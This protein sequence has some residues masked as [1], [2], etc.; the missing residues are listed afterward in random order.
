MKNKS[1][2]LLLINADSEEKG[3]SIFEAA[4]YSSFVLATAL[5]VFSFATGSVVLPGMNR[6]KA[7]SAIAIEAPA[8][9]PIVVASTN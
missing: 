7:D 9:Q 5:S 4:I 3:R 6:V 2:Y 1:T 8:Q